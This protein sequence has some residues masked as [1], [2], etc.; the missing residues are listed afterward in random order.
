MTGVQTCALPISTIALHKSTLVLALEDSRILEQLKENAQVKDDV[1]QSPT[2]TLLDEKGDPFQV[3]TAAGL[4]AVI[5]EAKDGAGNATKREGYLRLTTCQKKGILL[6]NQPVDLEDMTVVSA[7]ASVPLSV[8]LG[9][10]EPF[11][12][13]WKK[14]MKTVGQM[15]KVDVHYLQNAEGDSIFRCQEGAPVEVELP[16]ADPGFYTVCITTQG[17]QFYCFLV[18]AN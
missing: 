7:N 11:R 9:N 14:G 17:R 5:Y 18:Y 3:P 4:Y 1:T 13:S 8:N 12:I 2:L 16:F 15:K 10:A 6:Q